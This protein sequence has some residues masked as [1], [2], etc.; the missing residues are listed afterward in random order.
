M[1]AAPLAPTDRARK[2][3]AM[4]RAWA[5]VALSLSLSGCGLAG[6]TTAAAGGAA[7]EAQQAREAKHTEE[8]LKQQVNAAFEQAADQRPDAEEAGR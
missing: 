6:T 2:L 5:L 7:S 3:A 1:I 8:R 4:A